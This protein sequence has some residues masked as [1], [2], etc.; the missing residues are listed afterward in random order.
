M[1]QVLA[2]HPLPGIRAELVAPVLGAAPGQE[3]ASGKFGSPESSLALAVNG[4]GPFLDNLGALPPFAACSWRD[5]PA[6][7]PQDQTGHAKRVIARFHP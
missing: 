3:L 4:F 2:N 6:P 5:W 7:F 1:M